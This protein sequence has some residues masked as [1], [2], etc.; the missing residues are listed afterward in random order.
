MTT[1]RP[2][3]MKW[4]WPSPSR[5]RRSIR[6]E[7]AL[8]LG[9]L[10]LVLMVVTGGIVTRKMVATVTDNV[11][12]QLLAQSRSYAAAASKQ[13]IAA[14]GPDALLL[15]D[16][17]KKLM[18]DN[19]QC[20]WVGVADNSGT[21]LAHTD[22]R[23]V[24][25]GSKLSFAS[26]TQYL[27]RR[28]AGEFMQ[29]SDDSIIVAVPIT[30]QGVTL[31]T[32]AMAAS[33][34]DIAGVRKSA[35]TTVGLITIGM[36]LVGIPLTMIVLRRRLKPLQLITDSLR[37]VDSG[38]LKFDP[39]VKSANEFGYLA[40]TLRVMGGRLE[41]A[42]KQMVETERMTRDLEIAREIQANILPRHYPSGDA[43]EFAGSYRSAKE[44]GGD[45]YDFINIGG[46]KI[47]V[48][49][50]DVSGK[51]LPGML[52]MLLTRDLVIKHAPG[53]SRPTELL[54]T[55]NRDLRSEI[56]KGMFVTMFYGVLDPATGRFE[57]ASAGHNPLIH[58][59]AAG[60]SCRLIKTTG[61]PIGLMPPDRFDR[62]IQSGEISLSP[63]DWLIQYTDGI[64]EARTSAE[65]EYGMDRLI[66]AVSRATKLSAGELTGVVLGDIDSFVS[67]S[68]QFDDMTLLALKWN[69][70]GATDSR[71]RHE[72][73][74]AVCS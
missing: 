10:F 18:A 11:I 21:F 57:F 48:V 26:S 29:I 40:E 31:G 32:L 13:I 56:R 37:S 64:N 66:A 55:V 2:A 15:T 20:G 50:A 23:Q 3:D 35:L 43:F 72:V 52:V 44:V 19:P 30:E 28:R 62:R 9:G 12:D 59:E 33:T 54:S 4:E 22:M 24:V 42:R 65:K 25:A 8:Y 27:D 41:L 58:V 60:G 38:N 63:G 34:R 71:S 68:E 7:F 16:I 17:C 1:E 39:A 6:S 45:Y 70:F 47:G 61:F 67:D 74:N 14:D 36:I 73:S 51:S 5:Y 53:C 46:G 49:V 69:G